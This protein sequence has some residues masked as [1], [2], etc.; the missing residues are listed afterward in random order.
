MKNLFIVLFLIV[1]VYSANAQSEIEKI[2][3]VL[4]DYI[5]GTANG[6]PDRLRDCI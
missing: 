6:E 5:E 3:K 4:Y 1:A 2:N